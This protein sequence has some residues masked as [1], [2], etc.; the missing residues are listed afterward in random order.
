MSARVCPPEHK[1]SQTRTCYVN[2]SCRCTS[3]REGSAAEARARRAGTS[4]APQPVPRAVRWRI[5]EEQKLTII[6]L[7]LMVEDSALSPATKALALGACYDAVTENRWSRKQG[8][9]L[10][11]ACQSLLTI[12]AKGATS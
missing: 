3:C 8:R 2:H 9:E 10:I 11:S 5:T 7:A 4:I 6:D 12:T 1:H